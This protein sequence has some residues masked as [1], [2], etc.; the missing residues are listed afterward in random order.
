MSLCLFAA[1]LKLNPA[2]EKSYRGKDDGSIAPAVPTG[3]WRQAFSTTHRAA[4]W[5]SSV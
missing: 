1:E 3:E 4:R 5:I 2:A